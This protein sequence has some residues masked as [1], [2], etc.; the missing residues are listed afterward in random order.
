MRRSMVSNQKESLGPAHWIRLS[1]PGER[2][3]VSG[4][5]SVWYRTVYA[6]ITPWRLGEDTE[7]TSTVS[8]DDSGRH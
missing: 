1:A 5:N 8:S 4:V 2:S 6:T 7:T 3:L